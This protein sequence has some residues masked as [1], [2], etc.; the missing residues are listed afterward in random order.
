MDGMSKNSKREKDMLDG[1]Q[2]EQGD[3]NDFMEYMMKNG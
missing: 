2:T 3:A 1:V